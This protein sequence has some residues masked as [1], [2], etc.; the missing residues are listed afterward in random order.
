M[1]LSSGRDAILIDYTGSNFVSLNGHTHFEPHQAAPVGWYKTA[2]IDKGETL[3]PIV[4]AGVQ[5]VMFGA[6]AEPID[7]EQEFLPERA[8]LITTLRFRY[9]IK[10]RITSFVTYGDGI[11]C[12][13]VEVLESDDRYEASLALRLNAPM[14]GSKLAEF[15]R[16]ALAS[17]DKSG[18]NGI[19]F[20]YASGKYS[21]HGVLRASRRFDKFNLRKELSEK[22]FAEGIYENVRVGFAVSRTMIALSD[23]DAV[24]E[25]ALCER[26]ALGFDTIFAEHEREWR[27][28]FSSSDA[29]LPNDELT[30][31]YNLS[32]YVVRSYQHPDSGF[33]ALGM[34]PNHWH[35]AIYCSWDAMFPNEAALATGNVEL[36]EK[37]LDAYLKIAPECYSAVAELGYPGI[38]FPGWNTLAGKFFGGRSFEE[39]IVNFKP[40]FSAYFL[41]SLYRVYLFA[42]SVDIEKYRAIATD[43]IKFWLARLVHKTDEGNYVITSIKDGAETGCDVSVDTATQLDYAKAFQYVGRMYG[44]D[45]YEKIGD[46]MLRSL[47]LNRRDDGKLAAF[48]GSPFAASV[49]QTYYYTDE[50]RLYSPTTL[51]ASVEDMK[52]PF[53]LENEVAAEEYRHW[54]WND[55]WAARGF[56]LAK[57]NELARERILHMSYGASSLGALPEKI[58]LDGFPI[59]YWYSSMHSQFICAALD[60]FAVYKDGALLLCYGYGAE[61]EVACRRIR[62]ATGLEVSLKTKNASL[63]SLEIRNATSVGITV[64]LQLCSAFSAD[65]PSEITL[66]P[67]QTYSYTK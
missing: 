4:M 52:T 62:V 61:D 13:R 23:S 12:E 43:V 24:D 63:T 48:L 27:E 7:Y 34:Q 47:E 5:L 54:P 38:S 22:S 33:F 41:H 64:G 45:E 67:N 37:Y 59:N 66:A 30:Y 17:F 14:L 3:Q 28:Y 35:G 20:T 21:G 19:S 2:E 16:G 39:W 40:M 56:V 32:R 10:L 51:R 29:I 6:P 8:T 50:D 46:N 60:G 25:A 49:V 42:P 53:G 58:R 36:C 18:E 57:E 1:C 11:W 31:I 44:I 26:A 15:P 65:I 9:G 55:M